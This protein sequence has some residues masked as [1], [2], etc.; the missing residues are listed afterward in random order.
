[1]GLPLLLSQETKPSDNN[2]PPNTAN[3]GGGETHFA[4]PHI[5]RFGIPQGA[6]KQ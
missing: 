3:S 5:P 6:F 4:A 2:M 1:M